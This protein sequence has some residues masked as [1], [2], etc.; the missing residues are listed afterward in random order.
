MGEFALGQPVP[1]SEDPRLLR[2]GGRFVDDMVLPGMV[3]GYVLRS[4]HA[5]AN[6]LAID[7]TA[8]KAA[9]GVLAVLTGEDWQASG[10]GDL[11]TAHGRKRRDGSD[12]YVPPYPALVS[13]RVRRVGDYVAFVVAEDLN[14]AMDAAEL[15]EVDYQSL[16]SITATADATAPGAPLVWDDCADNICFVHLGGDKEATDQALAAADHV[17]SKR[18]IINRVSANPI[19]PRGSIGVYDRADDRS[20]TTHGV[21]LLG[22]LYRDSPRVG[23]WRVRSGL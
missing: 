6:I 7:T 22:R 17:V 19:E 8:A 16:P 3:H 15:I 20:C 2:G 12:M 1:R 14:H 21:Q 23:G 5:H 13:G 10:F 18:L 9:P 11:P 4:P